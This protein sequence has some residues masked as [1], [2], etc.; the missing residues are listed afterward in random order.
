MNSTGRR[1]KYLAID[2]GLRRIGIAISDDCRLMAFQRG[3]I[4]NEKGAAEEIIKLARNENVSKIIIGL[5]LNLKSGETHS[6]SSA[7]E[8]GNKLKLISEKGSQK[9][10]IIFYDERFTS[11]LAMHYLRESGVSKKKRQNKGIIDS[12]SAQIILE[13]YLASEKNS[14]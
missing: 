3:Y 4:S 7:R 6:T 8:F 10:E 2:F 1:D 11:S 12:I 5:P 9:I 14:E 13:D